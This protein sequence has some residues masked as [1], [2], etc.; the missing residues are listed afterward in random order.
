MALT[1]NY[2]NLGYGRR[3]VKP[4]K[5]KTKRQN[6]AARL[7]TKPLSIKA[8]LTKALKTKPNQTITR[9]APMGQVAPLVCYCKH[10]KTNGGHCTVNSAPHAALSLQRQFTCPRAIKPI[11]GQAKGRNPVM[12]NYPLRAPTM[13][14]APLGTV[15]KI[16]GKF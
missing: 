12:V 11:K 15:N 13:Y 10:S 7:N 1:T 3:K 6:K 5:T 4:N 16:P 14:G 9:P 2:A 8:K